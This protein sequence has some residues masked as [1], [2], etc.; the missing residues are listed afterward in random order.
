MADFL[1]LDYWFA[2]REVGYDVPKTA[3]YGILLVLA[4]YI[5]YKV[6]KRLKIKVDERLAVSVVPYVAFGSSLRVLKDAGV[7]RSYFFQT[8][9]IYVFVFSV[10]FAVLVVATALQ[11]K[12]KIEYYKSVFVI[13][14]FLLPFVFL[15][16]GFPNLYALF[17]V[18]ALLLPWVLIFRFVKWSTS[19]KIVSLVHMFDATTTFVSMS[20]FGY[21]EQHVVPTFFI[22]MFGPISFVILKLV[23]I[24]G[25]LYLIDKYTDGIEDKEFAP[26]LKLV[27]GILGAATGSRDLITLVAGI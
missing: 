1:N 22:N 27:I 20:F 16:M 21:F 2:P 18:G 25:V 8:P 9:G 11:K 7:V 5:I 17:I 24:V 10:F 15:Q 13:G 3:I 14:L 19:N 26:Y 23:A 6:L 4:V 12:F